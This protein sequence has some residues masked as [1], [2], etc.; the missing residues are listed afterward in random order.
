[1]SAL[2][3]RIPNA[4]L[5]AAVALVAAPTAAQ[6]AAAAPST[7]HRAVR[8]RLAPAAPSAAHRAVRAQ[9]APAAWAARAR[10]IFAI[11]DQ[12][13]G[14][15]T[16]PR[17]TWLGVRYARLIVPWDVMRSPSELAAVD[18]WMAGAKRRQIAPLV[19]FDQSVQS[20]RLL[21]TPP[22]FLREFLAFQARY[23]WVRDYTPW[24]EENLHYKPI[25]RHPGD[26]ALYF[27]VLSEHCPGCN[28]VA[29]DLLDLPNM[30]RYARDVALLANHPKLWGIHNY[31][32]VNRYS[33]RTTKQ[34]LA[35]VKGTIWFTEVGGVVWRK[36]RTKGLV[37]DGEQR[38][39]RAA[40]WIFQ[41]AKLSPRIRR[42]YYYQWRSAISLAHARSSRTST[43]DSGLI[44]STGL[45]RP[46]FDVIARQLGRDPRRAPRA[47]TPPHR[48]EVGVPSGVT[49]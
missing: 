25:A 32:D 6:L 33:T 18:L 2:R 22:R 17:V 24:N 11:G 46:A 37:V 14:L 43:W 23:P 20:P 1:V 8:A 15:F 26:A 13:P 19:A 3:N 34:L 16:D 39:A 42:I 47:P 10:P 4:L 40:A 31:V 28:V 45:P 44:D 30:V 41:L 5:A 12:K 36:D 21:P 9:L 35:A 38:A 7:A 48:L 29:A 27:N 49:P